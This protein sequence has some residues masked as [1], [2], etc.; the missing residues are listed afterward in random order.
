[1]AETVLP[2]GDSGKSIPVR[3]VLLAPDAKDVH[4][5]GSFNAWSPDQVQL[6]RSD[7]GLFHAVIHLPSGRYEYMFVIDGERWVTDPT[8]ALAV[9]DGFGNRNAVLEI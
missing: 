3:L 9:D 7:N 5:A 6:E 1:L 2:V 8:A 4:V